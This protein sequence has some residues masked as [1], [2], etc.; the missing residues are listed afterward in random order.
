MKLFYVNIIKGKN[1][2]QL[3]LK[4]KVVNQLRTKKL[5]S[6]CFRFLLITQLPMDYT[7]LHRQFS[8][9]PTDSKNNIIP[10]LENS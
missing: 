8:I 1:K 10:L 3:S 2:W 4:T 7:D 6:V 9:N 5:Q